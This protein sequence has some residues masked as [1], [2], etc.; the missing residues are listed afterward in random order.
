MCSLSEQQFCLTC[1]FPYS[2]M[3]IGS[4]EEL[5]K[6]L[7][8]F[9]IPVDELP[10]SMDGS[11]IQVSGSHARW[12]KKRRQ[13]DAELIFHSQALSKD[14]YPCKASTYP[15]SSKRKR[16]DA[17]ITVSSCFDVI[18][19][20]GR[21]DVC[22]GTRGT[23]LHQHT[24]NIAMRAMMEPLVEDYVNATSTRRQELNK[25]MIQA[26]HLIGGR[27]LTNQTTDGAWFEVVADEALV[28]QSIGSIFRGMVSRIN[29]K[30]SNG[31]KEQVM[32]QR[33]DTSGSGEAVD[34]LLKNRYVLG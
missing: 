19:I 24:G 30:K 11:E 27:F 17:T 15:L 22:L 25:I 16:D 21:H 34:D 1:P 13:K 20:P 3:I 5:K 32:G 29:A 6:T 18:D 7:K 4:F 12:M 8:T 9:G 23:T 33:S 14:T 2:W 26:V 28:E 10:Y 31:I